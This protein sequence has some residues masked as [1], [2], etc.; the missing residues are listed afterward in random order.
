MFI[1]SKKN[2][3]TQLM[4]DIQKIWKRELNF[5]TSE[6]G[7]N[8]PGVENGNLFTARLLGTKVKLYLEKII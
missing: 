1:C 6:K 3:V 4:L 5:T 2:Q 7:P 8:L